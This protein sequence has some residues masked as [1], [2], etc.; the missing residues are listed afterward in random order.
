MAK[1]V[2]PAKRTKPE[3]RTPSAKPEPRTKRGAKG[4]PKRKK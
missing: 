1:H 3:P 2:G 4:I